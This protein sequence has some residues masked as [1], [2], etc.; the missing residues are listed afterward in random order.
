MTITILITTLLQ[1]TIPILIKTLL[2]MTIP[3]TLNAG[4]FTLYGITYDINK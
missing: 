3:E 2:Q 4:D 1:I